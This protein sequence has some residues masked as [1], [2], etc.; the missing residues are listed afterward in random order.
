MLVI[1][2]LVLFVYECLK[3]PPTADDFDSQGTVQRVFLLISLSFD[4]VCGITVIKEKE[5]PRPGMKSITG[6]FALFQGILLV[7]T[8]VV[9]MI[10]VAINL[11][12][13]LI[14]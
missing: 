4:L 12:K 5:L 1:G 11:I 7:G 8:V 3:N 2:L 6:F 9:I 10:I 13:T 14:L